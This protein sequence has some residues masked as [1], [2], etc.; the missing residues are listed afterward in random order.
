MNKAIL[1]SSLLYI[2]TNLVAAPQYYGVL[3][4]GL[5]HSDFSNLEAS[6]PEANTTTEVVDDSDSSSY[7]SV[8]VGINWENSPLRSEIVYSSFGDQS[9]I[10]DTVFTSSGNERTTTN[11][12]QESLMFNLLYDIDIKSNVFKPYIGAGVGVLR[13]KVSATQSDEPATSRSA[14]FAEASDTNFMWSVVIGANYSMAETL[15]V[16]FGYRYTDAGEISTDDNCEG[17]DAFICDAGEKHSADQKSQL[18]FVSM[19]YYFE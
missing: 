1:A 11:I 4:M 17:S 10:E 2:S 5:S 16:G 14:S 12:K 7:F 18:L 13:S 3:E 15:M 6:T 9:F 19:N 8:G